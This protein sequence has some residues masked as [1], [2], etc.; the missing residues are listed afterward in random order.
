MNIPETDWSWTW[1][2][3]MVAINIVNILVCFWCFRNSL[4]A[5]DGDTAYLKRMRI[6]GLIFS[7]VALYR[8]IFVSRY[9]YQYCASQLI[10]R[11]VIIRL[12]S[13]RI[14][15]EVRRREVTQSA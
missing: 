2:A 5:V 12:R 9:L 1:W 3:G 11:V 15:G 6:M 4:N 14:D 13:I 7:L 8:S 10:D